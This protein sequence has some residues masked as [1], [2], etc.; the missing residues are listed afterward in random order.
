MRAILHMISLR[1]RGLM[2]CSRP[3]LRVRILS[4]GP[5]ISTTVMRIP[6]I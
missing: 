6:N 2:K 4:G 5:N 1:R 3:E